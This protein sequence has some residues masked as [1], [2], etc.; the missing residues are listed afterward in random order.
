MVHGRLGG[1]PMELLSASGV[2]AS[3]LAA[4]RAA[5]STVRLGE[6]HVAV[7][8]GSELVSRTL[9]TRPASTPDT[10]FLRWTLSDGAGAVVVEPRPRPD[11]LS[12]RVDW[13]H[14]ASHA[15][16]H[17]VCM[18]AG[19]DDL[20]AAVPGGTWLDHGTG[21]PAGIPAL[22]QDMAVLPRLLELGVAEFDALVKAGG[23]TR[24]PTTSCATS[25]P[26]T[27]AGNSS[28]CCAQPGTRPA[29]SAGSPT[30]TRRATPGRPAST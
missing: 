14:L 15:H 23:S 20:H 18:S 16:Q 24:R 11:G 12:L 4:L 13:L 2:C 17:P 28:I 10:G 30:C 26:S 5:V 22:R 27:S 9:L 19:L 29:R 25:A 6:H 7:A 1:G 8:A 21:Q 3:G